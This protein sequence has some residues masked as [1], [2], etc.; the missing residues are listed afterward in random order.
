MEQRIRELE[1]YWSTELK[2]EVIILPMGYISDPTEVRLWVGGTF[3]T[4]YKH[5]EEIENYLETY[6]M[7]RKGM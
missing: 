7:V 2:E 6:F 3:I 4:A 5:L 1:T